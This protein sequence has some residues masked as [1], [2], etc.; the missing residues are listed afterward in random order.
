MKG[1]KPKS[2]QPV[3]VAS[4]TQVWRLQ[5]LSLNQQVDELL[6]DK[7]YEEALILAENLEP[8]DLDNKEEK[9]KQIRVLYAYHQF[10]L[11]QYSRAMEY[12]YSENVSEPSLW[13]RSDLI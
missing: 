12:F 11:G 1:G 10:H 8:Q 2:G 7:E 9:L 6:R 3:Y 5:P 4:K 13:S